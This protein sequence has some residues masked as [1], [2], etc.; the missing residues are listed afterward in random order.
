MNKCVLLFFRISITCV[1][2]ITTSHILLSQLS[3]SNILEF[4]YGKLPTE[5]NDVF[6]SIYDRAVFNYRFKKFT[7]GVTL[8]NYFTQFDDRNYA[9]LSQYS[10]RYKHKKWDIKVGSLYETLGR[11]TLLRAF[12]VRGAILEDVGFRSRNYFHRDILGASA[13]YRTKKLT[14]QVMHGDILNNLLPP[15]KSIAERRKDRFSSLS[16]EFKYFKKHKAEFIFFNFQKD[17]ALA[18]NFVSGIFNGPLPLNMNYYAEY[19][20][21]ITRDDQI[22]FFTGITGLVGNLSYSLEYRR[23]RNIV[24]GSGINEPPPAIKMQTYRMLNRSTHVSNPDSEQ[25]YQLDVFYSFGDGSILNFNH[26]RA[27]NDFGS[28]NPLFQQYFV[29]WTSAFGEDVEYK[30]YLDY[31]K[32]DIKSESSRYSVGLYNSVKINDDL[33][34]LPEFELQQIERFGEKFWNQFYS[35]GIS[36]KSKLNLNFEI[37]MTKDPFLLED[38]NE[39]TLYP[40]MNLRYKLN[41]SHAAQVFV[42]QRRGGPA[43]SAGVCYEILDFRGLEFRLSS[44]F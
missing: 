28:F 12:E 27:R 32:D 21:S 24:L 37:E 15:T 14:L 38:G 5:V 34:L 44:R 16:A 10:L 30:L 36:Y 1:F 8:E 6:P 35:F 39:Q 29:E 13:K 31:S 9:S 43:C 3:G 4:Q 23:Y 20:T 2:L 17:N 7:A 25:G 33:T 11:G 42:G 41:R 18:N 22:A 40:G 19:S 26:A